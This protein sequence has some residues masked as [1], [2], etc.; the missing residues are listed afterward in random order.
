MRSPIKNNHVFIT[1]ASAGIGRQLALDLA[2]KEGCRLT[3]LDRDLEGLEQL[4]AEIKARGTS[5]AAVN[6]IRCD[7]ASPAGIAAARSATNGEAIDI[8]INSAGIFYSGAF[9]AMKIEDFAQLIDVDLMGTVRITHALLPQI[10]RTIVNISSLAGLIGSPGMCAYSTAKF[11]IVGFS[12]ALGA[13]LKGRI[14]VCTVCPSFVKTDIAKNTLFNDDSGGPPR[15]Q[16][17]AEMNKLLN[18]IGS[19]P[20]KVSKIVIKAIGQRKKL[21]LINPDAYFIYYINKLMPG[22]SGALIRGVYNT[23]IKKGIIHQ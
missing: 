22:A 2:I 18:K 16:T 5:E 1:G 15:E 23:L 9:E 10:K 3:L 17:V 12:Q 21:V 8:L 14:H 13:E 20:E 19:D 11:G 7:V 4:R 6:L